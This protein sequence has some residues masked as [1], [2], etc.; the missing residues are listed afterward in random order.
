MHADRCG[1]R[2]LASL[3]E[4]VAAEDSFRVRGCRMLSLGCMQCPGRCTTTPT[5]VLKGLTPC[6]HRAL[7]LKTDRNASESFAWNLGCSGLSD[8]QVGKC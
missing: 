7:A 5:L 1:S 2:K 8:Q 4:R 6:F 3:Q